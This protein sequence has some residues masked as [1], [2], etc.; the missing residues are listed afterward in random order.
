MGKLAT[1]FLRT[2]S[3]RGCILRPGS[4]SFIHAFILANA[5]SDSIK[6]TTT[7]GY[8][9]VSSCKFQYIEGLRMFLL[10]TRSQKCCPESYP[11]FMEATALVRYISPMRIL[12]CVRFRTSVCCVR[13]VCDRE[14]RTGSQTRNSFKVF[15]ASGCIE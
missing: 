5:V 1:P 8:G 11:A 10:T 6:I 4:P 2:R 14:E 7:T 12:L 3:H 9:N 13:F 15:G